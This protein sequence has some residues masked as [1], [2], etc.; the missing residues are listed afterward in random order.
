MNPDP[1]LARRV[2]GFYGFSGALC[3][4]MAVVVPAIVILDGAKFAPL[5]FSVGAFLLGCGWWSRLYAGAIPERM[6]IEGGMLRLV[7]PDG[8][9][10][11]LRLEDAIHDERGLLAGE[12]WVP[13]YAKFRGR[14]RA[15]LYPPDEIEALKA[16]ATEVGAV[17][18]F[19]EGLRRG[20]LVSVAHA[21]I[22]IGGMAAIVARFAALQGA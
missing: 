18:F 17:G 3:L 21:L 4:V 13:F 12:R 9:R 16:R 20:A 11:L 5:G 1:M 8:R 22:G 19:L 6:T 7:W 10:E 15:S 14:P 2:R